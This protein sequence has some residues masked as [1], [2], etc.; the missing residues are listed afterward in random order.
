MFIGNLEKGWGVQ[1]LELELLD[2]IHLSLSVGTM[3]F[4][5]VAQYA[6]LSHL[7]W[8][9]VFNLLLRVALSHSLRDV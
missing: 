2:S 5:I 9:S 6:E 3:A 4:L 7:S 8:F 1:V